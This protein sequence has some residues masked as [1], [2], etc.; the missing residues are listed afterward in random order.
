MAID[1]DVPA[2]KHVRAT[3][4]MRQL[5]GKFV[6]HRSAKAI[7]WSRKLTMSENH[8]NPK[9]DK[10]K[11]QHVRYQEIRPHRDV[12]Q[13]P[14]MDQF[15]CKLLVKPHHL[16]RDHSRQAGNPPVRKSDFAAVKTQKRICSREN[17]KAN[18]HII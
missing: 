2:A 18:L 7:L 13:Q 12:I 16:G 15:A 9:V 14:W 10:A 4:Y 3:Y 11:S 6:H 17:A 8:R 5:P 1:Y